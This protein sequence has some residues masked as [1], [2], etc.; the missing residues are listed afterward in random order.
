VYKRQVGYRVL[1]SNPLVST[2]G[3]SANPQLL[4]GFTLEGNLA[5]DSPDPIRIVI[6]KL[7]AASVPSISVT[8]VS[9]FDLSFDLITP[10]GALRPYSLYQV[11]S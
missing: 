2:L 6:P 8:G 3:L 4:D 7:Q 5:T 10:A 9:K 1:K 11:Y